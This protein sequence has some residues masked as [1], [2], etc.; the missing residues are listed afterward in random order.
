MKDLTAHVTDKVEVSDVRA[1]YLNKSIILKNSFLS[2]LSSGYPF[3]INT[4]EP[5]MIIF[6][7]LF[8]LLYFLLG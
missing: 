5:Y 4:D 2:K 7:I 1:T 3:V 6:A 8:G